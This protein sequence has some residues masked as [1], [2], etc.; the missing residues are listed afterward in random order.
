MHFAKA[1][2][3]C[4]KASLQPWD[5]SDKSQPRLPSFSWFV[6]GFLSSPGIFR[7][8]SLL[9]G[10]C[11]FHEFPSI[12]WFPQLPQPLLDLVFSRRVFDVP[13]FVLAGLPKPELR[14]WL[15]HL[16]KRSLIYAMASNGSPTLMPAEGGFLPQSPH[17]GL[18]GTC[19]NASGCCM[20]SE[21]RVVFLCGQPALC[22]KPKSEAR[23][24]SI[25][26][27]S[28]AFQPESAEAV[29][30]PIDTTE[31]AELE[32][33]TLLPRHRMMAREKLFSTLGS[34]AMSSVQ[35]H[36]CEGVWVGLN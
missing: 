3:P 7:S 11:G 6:F 36:A 12:A 34:W 16:F 8:V 15:R 33:A 20:K 35:E 9:S 5:V 17:W 32:R 10:A 24:L 31:D 22:L 14:A 4:W 23:A 29:L 2:E 21:S 25:D 18:C 1:L 30:N 27:K 26:F 19:A 13:A 28:V